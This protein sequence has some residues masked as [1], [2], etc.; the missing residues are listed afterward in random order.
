MAELRGFLLG[1][2]GLTGDLLSKSESFQLFL[3]T[4]NNILSE[5]CPQL[6]FTM[7]VSESA[8][9]L[10]LTSSTNSLLEDQERGSRRDPTFI[11][12]CVA[13][14]VQ[15]IFTSRILFFPVEGSVFVPLKLLY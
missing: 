6:S 1:D 13:L 2:S 4:S 15:N 9:E 3:L 7:R 5:N 11:Y 14:V 8:S 10:G 12:I